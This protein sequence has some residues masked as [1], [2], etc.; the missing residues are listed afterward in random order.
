[1]PKRCIVDSGALVA[2]LDPREEHHHWAKSAFFY[3]PPPWLACEAVLTE[4]FYLLE[5]PETEAL[6]ALLRDNYLKI[7]FTLERELGPVLDFR[8]KY[9]R[10]PM[11]LAD[12]CIVRMSE[13]LPRADILST[14]SDFRIYRRF[15]RQALPHVLPH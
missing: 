14:N 15:N 11:S 4:S 2:L 7:A 3:Y 6:E 1:M 13:L 12:A 5:D 9:A 8:K 10:V